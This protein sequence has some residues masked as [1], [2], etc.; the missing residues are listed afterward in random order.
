VHI[1]RYKGS[2]WDELYR[3]TQALFAGVSSEEEAAA[4]RS[5]LT[6]PD[7][8]VFV[9][10]RENGK[11]AGYVEAGERS[12]VDGCDTSPVGYIEAWY[13]DPDVRRT[14]FGRRLLEAG[15]QW[16]RE[17]GHSEM[18]SDALLENDVS[19]LAHRASDYVETGRVINYRKELAPPPAAVNVKQAVP[20]FLVKD[21]QRSVRFHTDGLGGAIKFK[22]E[23]DG[24]LRWCWI[25][26][27]SAA[28]MLQEFSKDD[29]RRNASGG[30][31]GVGV[32]INF[33]C[34][35]AIAYYRQLRSRGIDAQVPF[36]GNSFWVTSV[37]DPDGYELFFESPTDAP[38]ESVYAEDCAARS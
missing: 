11:L 21:M 9:L 29:P 38:E 7:G 26:L 22:W 27:G 3:L 31:F 4:L 37:T 24:S 23:V 30:K 15:E 16:A 6:R 10:D 12:V 2:D 19:H 34:A 28:L 36:V 14:G 20:F 33:I 17:R 35:D 13:V 25:D 8:A 18:G 32:S 1:R 5:S